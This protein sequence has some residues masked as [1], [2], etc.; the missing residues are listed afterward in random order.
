MSWV[1][2]NEKGEMLAV[3]ARGGFTWTPKK[4]DALQFVNEASAKAVASVDTTPVQAWRTI[5][6]LS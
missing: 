3:D 1:I 5:E 4:D 2:K 6:E